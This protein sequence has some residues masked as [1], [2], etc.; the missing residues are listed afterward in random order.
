MDDTLRL[1][2]ASTGRCLATWKRHSKA[3]NSVAVFP[4]GDRVVSGSADETLKL[5]DAST[6]EC[7]AT[8]EGH[9]KYVSSVA[10]F[11]SGEWVVSGSGDRTLKL[12]DASTGDCLATWKGGN[13][14]SVASFPWEGH[15]DDVNS[16][17]VF[18][19]GNRVVSGSDDK[20]LKLWG[21]ARGP[22]EA[23]TATYD[24]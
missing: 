6:G 18:P 4:S 20:T 24:K 8:W 9:S 14:S 13:V 23:R 2:D 3:V 19:S 11:P 7:L 5:W 10:V 1:W 12:W 17:A 21:A 15:K 22:R 16:V